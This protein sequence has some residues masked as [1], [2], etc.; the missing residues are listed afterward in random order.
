MQK[1]YTLLLAVLLLTTAATAQ[2]PGCDGTRYRSNVFSTVKKTT[3]QYATGPNYAGLLSLGLPATVALS[4]DIYEPEG[5]NL[6][7]RPAIVVAHGGSFIFGD[8]TQMKADCER[9]AKQGYVAASI[10]YRLYPALVLG[11][12]D[13]TN[14]IEAVIKAV[15]DMKAAV[16]YLREDFATQNQFRIDTAHIYIGGYSA[17]A[18]AAL[19]TAYMDENTVLPAF[20]QQQLDANGG[21]NGNCGSTTN[22]T[23][24]S[25]VG[26]VVNRSGGLYRSG[27]VDAGE[28]PLVSI[29]GTADNVVYYESGL[30][31]GIAYLEGSSR[32]HARALQVGVSSDLTT[33]EGG[34]HSDIYESAAYAAQLGTFWVKATTLLEA[35]TCGIS[36]ATLP[37]TPVLVWQLMPNPT[38]GKV[39]IQLPDEINSAEIMVVD[40]LGRIAL[41]TLLS[42]NTATLS[43]DLLPNGMY[44]L[45]I[46]NAD[47][48]QQFEAK[49]LM[50]QH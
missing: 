4:M 34:G 32:V 19:H 33:V 31:A 21:I 47:R 45:L 42:A 7:A 16:R 49:K 2:N 26:A 41:R 22:Q 15:G 43:V 30:A 10:S 8:R 28:V 9:L 18:V 6:T 39:Q 44:T 5:D 23:Y 1:N 12:P 13:S 20:I 35:L 46:N 38:S 40:Q 3:V 36:D 37:A 29:H 27:W 11:F 48:T 14:I 25:R 24:S 17:G 50:I